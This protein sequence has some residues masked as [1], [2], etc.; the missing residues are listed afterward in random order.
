MKGGPGDITVWKGSAFDCSSNEIALIHSL[1]GSDTQSQTI[2][3]GE[4]NNGSIRAHSVQV[5][6]NCYTSQL[7]ITV[8]ADMIGKT[9]E[10]AHDDQSTESV[11]GT[12]TVA[13]EGEI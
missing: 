9:I 8:N 2:A 5:E 11:I 13:T 1:F 3:A 10:C 7:N 6:D 4:C 12:L